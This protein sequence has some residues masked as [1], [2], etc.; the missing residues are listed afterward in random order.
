MKKFLLIFLALVMMAGLAMAESDSESMPAEAAVF[1][2]EWQCD[3]ATAELYWEEEGFKVMISWGSSAW[4]TTRWEYSCFYQEDNNTLRSMPFGIKT[5]LVFDDNSE[6]TSATAV[7]DDG[8]AT[9]S[10][11][12]DGHLIWIDEKE[13]A[14]DGMHFEKLDVS[15]TGIDMDEIPSSSLYKPVMS[16]TFKTLVGGKTFEARIDGKACYGEDEDGRYTVTI[17]VCEE[18]HYEADIANLKTNDI[19]AFT[20]DSAVMAME[21]ASDEFGFS[22]KDGNNDGYIFTKADDGCYTVRTETDNILYTAVFTVTVPLEKDISFLDWSDPE[23]LEAPVEKGYDELLDLLLEDTDFA[24]YNTK[25]TFDGN[26]K[27]VELL[28]TYSPWN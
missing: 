8:L 20:P 25:V 1:E 9:F 23:N 13:N 4:E 7:Y 17:T 18:T 15:E 6:I 16:E 11:D 21:V 19:V 10:I 2:G 28:Y 24:P 5:E 22:I 14:G 12:E 26:G 27:L 3:R